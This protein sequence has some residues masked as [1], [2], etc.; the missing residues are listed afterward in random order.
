MPDERSSRHAASPGRVPDRPPIARGDVPLPIPPPP[1]PLAH[2]DLTEAD[3][4]DLLVLKRQ[5]QAT[6]GFYCE[7]YKE[8]CLR[9]RI[10]VRM[11]AR[12][13]HAYSDYATLLRRDPAEYEKLVDALTINVSKFYRN[14]EVWEA[15]T[16]RVMPVL[17]ALPDEEIRIWSAGAASGEE[18]YT[19]SILLQEYARAHG[20]DTGRF[21]ILGTDIDRE[22][23]AFAQRAEY[24]DFAM[25]D[26]DPALRDR[27]F[28]PDGSYRLR[29]Q[30]RRGVQF[31]VLDLIRD[32]YPQKQHL[33]F[34]R[35]VIIYFERSIQ[36][37]L[38]ARFHDALLPGGFLVLGK[39]E[40]LFG[41]TAGLFQTVAN[42]Q[43]IF[44]RP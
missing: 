7:G 42:R 22:S 41:Q 33:I 29:A 9:R 1:L 15:I 17:C 26:I 18:P 14:P 13:V 32:A 3:A 23:L 38:F 35:N 4:A 27:W 5:I 31:E 25:T 43:R 37:Q 21:R 10:A 8:K 12:G 30:A 36:E 40:A 28:E 11:R 44:R 24:T 20:I 2:G 16:D 6:V 34:C 39:V 19:I